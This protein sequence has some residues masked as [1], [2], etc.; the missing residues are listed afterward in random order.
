MAYSSNR[1]S[2]VY[3]IH[4]HAQSYNSD[5]IITLQNILT[6]QISI[7]LFKI[8]EQNTKIQANETRGSDF[9]T[10][11]ALCLIGGEGHTEHYRRP[12]VVSSLLNVLITDKE[13][14]GDESLYTI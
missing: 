3:L 12:T 10:S 4:K 2:L 7:K 11:K 9:H 14:L 8:Q 6:V 13:L 1:P 5:T